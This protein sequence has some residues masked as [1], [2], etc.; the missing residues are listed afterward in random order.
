MA[1][2]NRLLTDNLAVA[3]GILAALSTSHMVNDMMQ[4]LILAMYPILKGEFAPLGI[5]G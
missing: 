3:F 5:F 4:S 1:D 2:L